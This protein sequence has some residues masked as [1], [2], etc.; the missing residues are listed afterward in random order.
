MLTVEELNYI[1]TV[2]LNG[3]CGRQGAYYDEQVLE[4]LD[5]LIAIRERKR[6]Q[7]TVVQKSGDG[8]RGSSFEI[9]DDRG[10]RMPCVTRA[11]VVHSLDDAARLAVTLVVNGSDIVLKG[12]DDA[13]N[14]GS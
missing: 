13:S 3:T 7:L 9:R 10:L 12:V 11:S 5:E 14:Q 4:A 2:C 6:M 8:V 1:R